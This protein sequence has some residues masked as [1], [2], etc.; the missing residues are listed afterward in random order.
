VSYAVTAAGSAGCSLTGGG[1]TLSATS[2][3]TCT[4]TA[5]K[6]ADA[7]YNEVSSTATTV[8]FA[9]PVSSPPPPP[10]GATSSQNCSS[11]S[12]SG[13]CNTTNDQTT[14]S[15]S[16]EGAVTVSQYPSDPVSSPSFSTSG[17]Y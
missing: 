12:S 14:V 17:E 9:T 15:G 4:V 5:T 7:N 10:S 3:G 13:T 16:G 1:T 11:S 2:A 8:T 6:A